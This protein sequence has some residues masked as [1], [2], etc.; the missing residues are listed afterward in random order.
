[1]IPYLKVLSLGDIHYAKVA[2]RTVW[3]LSSDPTTFCIFSF[4]KLFYL[5]PTSVTFHLC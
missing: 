5:L 2:T 4:L 1:M 3:V